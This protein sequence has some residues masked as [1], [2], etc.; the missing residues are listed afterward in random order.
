MD[1]RRLTVDQ[2][3][4]AVGIS[5]EQVENNLHDLKGMLSAR[6]VQRPLTPDQKLTRLTLSQ[7]NLVIF[8]VDLVSYLD[9]FL[10]QDNV[11]STNW[12]QRQKDIRCD[13]STLAHP[14]QSK[15]R[16]SPLQGR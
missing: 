4:N 9:L 3:D 12:S 14:L 10:I 5:R 11:G 8:K 7:A 13:G 6:W 16:S 2:I 15:Q 1:A